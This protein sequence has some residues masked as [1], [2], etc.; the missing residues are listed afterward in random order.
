MISRACPNCRLVVS[1]GETWCRNCGARLPTSSMPG[2]RSENYA[3]RGEQRATS[4]PSIPEYGL[5]RDSLGLPIQGA[6]FGQQ[7]GVWRD[8][9]TLIMHK[10]ARLPDYCIKCGVE[11][12]G[13]H[14][15]KKLSWHHPALALL[16]LAGL[17]L[18]LIVA[19]IVRKSATVEISLCEDHLRKHRISVIATW[20]IF[21][22]GMVSM[23]AAIAA[24][25]GGSALFGLLLLFA[26]AI[27]A[28]TWA[29][30]VTVKRIDDHYVWLKGIDERFLAILPVVDRS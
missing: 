2:G 23:V 18:Y 14:L 8:G 12:N 10:T 11:A 13:S 4:D 1:S 20:L 3:G 7:G 21:L 30:I 9:T 16:V 26:S 17:L 24:E 19:L 27:S 29:K 28:L 5:P 22:A 25:S 6:S 15:R